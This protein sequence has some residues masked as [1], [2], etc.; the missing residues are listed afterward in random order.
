MGTLKDTEKDTGFQ[1]G[2]RSAAPGA[3]G[4]ANTGAREHGV[5]EAAPQ[6]SWTSAA[7]GSQGE[8]NTRARFNRRGG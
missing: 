2:R 5:E 1:T 6:T 7:P 8:A 4:Q 3:Q